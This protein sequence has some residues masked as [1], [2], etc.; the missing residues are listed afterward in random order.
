MRPSILP[1]LI[2]AAGRNTDRGHPDACIF[3]IGRV[4]KSIDVAGQIMTASGLRAGSAAPRHW[5]GGARAVDAFD[6]KAD[7]LAVLESCGVNV[8]SLQITTEAPAY[9]HPGRSGAMKLGRD[10]LA[11]FG[12]IHPAVLIT[13]KR[14]ETYAG[15]EVFLPALPVPKN[16]GTKKDMLKLS[17]FQ[18]LRRDFAFI[19][20]ERTEAEKLLRAIRGTDKNLITAVDIFDVYQG[21]G[22]EAGK[23]SLAL[24]VT[25]QPMEKTL[26]DEEINALCQ[27]IIEAAQK[28]TGAA[29][30]A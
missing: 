17:A 16:K 23:K 13:M 24:G 8:A 29:L 25:I 19:V 28:Q 26:T 3:E 6:V 2:A 30:R 11:Y 21:K 14:D 20:D 4:F 7:A 15:F 5:S 9:Y 10:V 1:N 27:K 18:P 12:E 22:V